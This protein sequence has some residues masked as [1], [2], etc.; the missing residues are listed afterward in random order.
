M[1]VTENRGAV[2]RTYC[3]AFMARHLR[4]DRCEVHASPLDCPDFVVVRQPDGSFVMPIRTGEGG[5]AAGWLP[6]WHCPWCG[7]ALAGHRS[8]AAVEIELDGPKA[9]TR[10]EVERRETAYEAGAGGAL[11]FLEY[12]GW[13]PEEYDTW[14]QTGKVPRS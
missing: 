13:T 1:Q 14:V 12:L 11:T 2:N 5:S 9:V 3:C 7:E 8:T 4:Q 10:R 6:A